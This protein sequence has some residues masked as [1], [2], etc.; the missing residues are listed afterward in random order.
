MDPTI[1]ELPN[2]A[3]GAAVTLGAWLRNEAEFKTIG[4]VTL[5]L[6]KEGLKARSTQFIQTFAPQGGQ[7]WYRAMP[8]AK[9]LV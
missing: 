6:D 2:E 7:V 3:T 1:E 4:D 8:F 5:C 9:N